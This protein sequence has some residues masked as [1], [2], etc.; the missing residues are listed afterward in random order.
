MNEVLDFAGFL[1]S[2]IGTLGFFFIYTFVSG[3]IRC[4]DAFG[5]DMFQSGQIKEFW[6]MNE[7]KKNFAFWCISE[8]MSILFTITAIGFL[9]QLLSKIPQ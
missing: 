8:G 9:L 1:M 4:T 6:M 5:D 2:G 7:K 3:V